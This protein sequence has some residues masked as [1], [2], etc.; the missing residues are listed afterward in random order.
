MLTVLVVILVAAHGLRLFAMPVPPG[1]PPPGALSMDALT[2]GEWWTVLTSLFT[3]E[4]LWHL[5][6]NLILLMLAG[7]PV[8][9][10]G[11]PRHFTYIFLASA[12]VGAAVFL[13]TNREQAV[14]GASGGAIGMVGAFIAMN[15]DYNVMRPFQ[16]FVRL[17]LRAKY[18]FPALLVVFIAQEIVARTVKGIA[19]EGF[20]REAHLVHAAGLLTGWLY[21]RRL[22]VEARM[23]EEWAD[24]FPQGMRR[25][26]QRRESTDLPV[27]AGLPLQ[28]IT[29]GES[30]P[31]PVPVR[32]LTDTEFLREQVDPVLEKLYASGAD[33]LTPEERAVLEEAS[34]RFSRGGT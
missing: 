25:R 20:Y 13:M 6:P 30:P 32:E 18:L 14:I 16:R 19:W 22:S 33:K 9:R 10:D 24:F 29:D 17:R 7:R 21:G 26:F 2:R 27:A 4:G 28:E 34:R 12:W 5:L 15:G 31:P 8:E 23:R 11:G 1:V 3:H